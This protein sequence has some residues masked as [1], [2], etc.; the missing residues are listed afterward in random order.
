VSGAEACRAILIL[1]A[2]HESRPVPMRQV[3]LLA[4]L[5]DITP[6][7]SGVIE[8]G[9]DLLLEET[10]MG[11]DSFNLARKELI[12]AGLITYE[13]G[14]GRGKRSR[15]TINAPKRGGGRAPDQ[16]ERKPFPAVKGGVA[17][18]KRG[19]GDPVKGGVV[20]PPDLGE[21]PP[22]RISPARI[23]PARYAESR[24]R[25]LDYIE[26]LTGL[27]RDGADLV[28]ERIEEQQ[29]RKGKPVRAPL[30]FIEHFGEDEL[31]GR[32]T[33]QERQ[34]GDHFKQP[35]EPLCGDCGLRHSLLAYCSADPNRY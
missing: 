3:K 31:L 32:L 15:W 10:G 35:G 4:A 5:G 33:E 24:D 18:D 29:E 1:T 11:V 2:K 20:P 14:Q 8:A 25:A 9:R 16:H 34:F 23:N 17:D 19:G 12:E 26:E 21:L 28:Y 30:T 27:T 13:P 6:A 7:K 22:A